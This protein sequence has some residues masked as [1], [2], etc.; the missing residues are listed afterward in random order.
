MTKYSTT[1][2]GYLLRGFELITRPGLRRFV[3]VPL[4]LNVLIFGALTW[5]AASEFQQFVAWLLSYVPSWLQW[6]AW[7]LWPLFALLGL[8]VIFFSFTLVANFIGAPFNGLLA[9]AVEQQL[10]GRAPGGQSWRKMLRDVAP[11]LWGEARKLMY[12]LWRAALLLPLF[13][14]PGVNVIAPLAWLAFSAWMMALQYSDYPLANHGVAFPA[15][16]RTLAAHRFTALS[17]GGAVLLATLI[18]LL[19]FFVM[20][21]AVAGA[22]ALWTERLRRENPHTKAQT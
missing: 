14:I 19:N 13:I 2:P 21:A 17:F 12:F 22:T 6:L 20:P 7:L 4:L 1:G 8:I 5:F 3:I 9:E 11:S 18:P 15:Q 16:R 10:T